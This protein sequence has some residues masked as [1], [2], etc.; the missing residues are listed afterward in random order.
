MTE[1]VFNL[2]HRE[3]EPSPHAREGHR[4]LRE[5]L[6]KT[7]GATLTGMSLYELP[8]S[9]KGSP[10]HYELNREE[11]LVVVQGELVVR[12]PEGERTMRE[13]DVVCFPVG[14]AGLHTMRN[15]SNE[16]ARYVMPSSR[17]P[18]GY[19]AVRPESNTVVIFGPVSTRSCRWTTRASS[20][21]ASRE[22]LRRRALA[23]RP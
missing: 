2:R 6:G 23:A 7:V 21:R 10:Y 1:R 12:T 17:P 13:G 14:E 5:M 11:W 18:D 15:D 4:F 9:E 3:L 16:S 22:S 19:V 8:P 20:G